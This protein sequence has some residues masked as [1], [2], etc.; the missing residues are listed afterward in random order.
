MPKDI[1][2]NG[3]SPPKFN[4]STSARKQKNI[5]VYKDT[6]LGKTKFYLLHLRKKRNTLL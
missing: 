2:F 3:A 1:L 4:Q 5:I 6:A